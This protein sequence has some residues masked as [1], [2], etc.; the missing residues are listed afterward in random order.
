MCGIVGILNRDIDASVNPQLLDDACGRIAHRGPD[1]HGTFID[2][3]IGLG[4]R[5]LSII[6]VSGG[7]QP[8][9]NEDGACQIVFNGEIYNHAELRSG[10]E[11]RGHTF[12]TDTDTESILHLYEDKGADCVEA[13]NGMFAFAIFDRRDRSVLIARDRLGIKPLFYAETPSGLVFGSEI[14]SLLT[15]PD[16]SRE[17]DPK[18]LDDYLAYK[19]IPAPRT[20]YRSVRKLPPGHTLTWKDGTLTIKPYWHLDFPESD[21]RCEEEVAEELLLRLRES[22]RLRM[23]SDVPLGAFLSGG[24]DSS[25]IVGLMSEM[26]DQPVRTFSIGFEEQSY[27]ELEPARRV[28]EHFGTL[29]TDLVVT[30]DVVDL[31]QRVTRQFDEPFGDSSA[32]PTY[33]VSKLA[34]EHVK[35]ALSGTGADEAF[36]GYER[37][38]MATLGERYKSLPGLLTRL[39]ESALGLLDSG[40]EKK[41]T[42]NRLK[43]FTRASRLD[44][45]SRHA[46]ILGL[47]EERTSIYSEGFRSQLDAE[48]QPSDA[49]TDRDG[50]YTGQSGL[51]RLLH[52][53]TGTTLPD[54]YLCKDDRMSMANSLELRVPFLDHTLVEFAAGLPAEMKLKGLTTKHILRKAVKGLV[55]DAILKRPKHGFEIPIAHWLC[56]ELKA[57]THDHLLSQNSY[58]RNII[59]PDAISAM[60]TDHE[61]GRTNHARELWSLIALEAWHRSTSCVDSK[62]TVSLQ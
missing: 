40:H 13:L 60:V 45:V 16:V 25:A 11:K 8:I 57:F 15:H 38:W 27:S 54:D 34:S 32:L 35:V 1:D 20:I 51:G 44:P 7:R 2:R 31:C 12:S 4:M 61:S 58:V 26:A 19:F 59:R 48:R 5:R 37:Y 23:I 22:V 53:D 47:F 24:I 36:A 17:I 9:S 50:S 62:K 41:S 6:D 10:S 43:R 52:L 39:F 33:L 29:H 55:P 42:V 28:S 56:D 14:K 30:P 3:N 49:L 21:T 18:A 46:A